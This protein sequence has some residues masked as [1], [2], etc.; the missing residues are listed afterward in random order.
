MEQTLGVPYESIG[1]ADEV[2]VPFD[3]VA[4][5]TVEI[6]GKDDVFISTTGNEK[7]T[8]SLSCF[9]LWLTVKSYNR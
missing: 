8:T 6:K 4:N 3:I 7:K 5:R 9:Q 2:P 1:N